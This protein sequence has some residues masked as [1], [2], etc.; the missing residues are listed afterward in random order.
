[1]S[2]SQSCPEAIGLPPEDAQSGAASTP[3]ERERPSRHGAAL[4]EL[5]SAL[6]QIGREGAGIDLPPMCATCAYRPGCMTNQMAAT[7]ITALNCL[8]GIDTDRFACHHGMKDGRPTKLCAGHVAALLAP[9][10]TIK[11]GVEWLAR[12]LSEGTEEPDEIRRE[13]DA[14][15][16]KADPLSRM[17]DYARGRAYLRAKVASRASASGSEPANAINSGRNQTP[18]TDRQLRDDGQ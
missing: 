5:L 16:A 13:F 6:E 18:P 17:D 7:G 8:T 10:D 4:G 9:W 14:W 3:V 1:M 12:R 11:A 15:I 2:S